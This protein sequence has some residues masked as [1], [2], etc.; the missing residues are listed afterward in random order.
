MNSFINFILWILGFSFLCYA[1]SDD[2]LLKEPPGV[3]S[4]SVMSSP[5]GVEALLVGAYSSLQGRSRFGGAMGT[6]WTYGSGAS[7][8]CYKGTSTGDQNNYNAVERYE[9]LPSNAYMYDRWRDCYDGVA[10]TN[11][12][13]EF[14]RLNQKSDQAIESKRATIIEAEAKFLRAWFHFK[15][16]KI[17]WKIPYVK[18]TE[19]HGDLLPEEVPNDSEGWEEIETDLQWAIDHL[20]TDPPSGEVGRC[21]KYAAMAV[22]AHVHLYQ[23]EYQEAK[24]LLDTI[25]QSGQY[26]LVDNFYDNYDQTTENNIE[27]IFEIQA[28]TSGTNHSAML[29]AG[30]SMHQSGPAGLG[31]GFYQPSQNLFEAFQV[32]DNGLPILSVEDRIALA[33]DM[34]IPS[35][36][37]FTPTTH[38]LDP[39]VDWTISRRGIDYLGWGIC[40]GASWIR[41]QDNGG[42]YMTKKFMQKKENQSLNTFGRGFDNGKNFRAYRYSHI[43]LWRAEV[44]VEENDLPLARVLVNLI[45]ARAQR[46]EVVMG[47]VS[48]NIFDG[49]AIE[50]E[51]SQPAAN[52]KV[53]P[54]PIDSP[55]FQSQELARTAV[56]LEI[57]LEFAT[58][59]HRFFDLR[60]WGIAEKVLNDYIQQDVKFRSFLTGATFDGQKDDYWPIP[61]S[62]LDIQSVLKQ[63]PDYQ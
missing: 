34:G 19:E 5:E 22:K 57:R 50:V 37:E 21:T 1:C 20:P 26:Q 40:E 35:N 33:N 24:P 27:S 3:A 32:D 52:Y 31:W 14:L 46:S 7:D 61:E 29:L 48:T 10:R 28:A 11:L 38:L 55:T 13:L 45:R 18:T 4:G 42:P 25:I 15:A 59:G 51:W 36:A 2:F 49:R 53:E 60:R 58:E 63:D 9:V 17:F 30:P 16:T 41:Q 6:D 23:Q 54:Y 56:R 44:A 62:Q 39:R 8:D 12:V 43:L 47:K